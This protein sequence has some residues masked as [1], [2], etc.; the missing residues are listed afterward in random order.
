PAAGPLLVA[1]RA[2]ERFEL[3]GLA[4]DVTDDVEGVCVCAWQG[5]PIV[6]CSRDRAGHTVLNCTNETLPP[7]QPVTNIS[8]LLLGL[9][10]RHERIGCVRAELRDARD[11]LFPRHSLFDARAP[12]HR[13]GP[14][15]ASHSI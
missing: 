11:R 6:G 13:A 15:D 10:R 3:V 1:K 8:T 7:L 14:A 4:V 2:Q 9:W 5:V 12:D